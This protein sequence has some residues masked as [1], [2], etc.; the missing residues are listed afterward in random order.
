MRGC[1]LRCAFPVVPLAD[2]HGLSIGFTTVRERACFGLYVDRESL[3]D[4][5]ALA[6]AIGRELDELLEI[7]ETPT[8]AMVAV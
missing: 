8:A 5:D 6:A 7:C 3:P 1:E 4:S 2:Q